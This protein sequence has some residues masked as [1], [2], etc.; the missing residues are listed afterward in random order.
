MNCGQ[1]R[2]GAE[3]LGGGLVREED[4][5]PFA[6]G[7]EIE[8]DYL[9]RRSSEIDLGAT[10]TQSPTGPPARRGRARKIDCPW[11]RAC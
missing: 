8:A 3:N 4:I 11:R 9:A 10:A 2:I 5:V 6:G 7:G 1:V